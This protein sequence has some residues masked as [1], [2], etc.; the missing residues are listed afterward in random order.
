MTE[1]TTYS[2]LT[3]LRMMHLTGNTAIAVLLLGF[4]VVFPTMKLAAM[5]WGAAALAVGRRPAAAVRL[6]HHLGKFSMLDVLVIALFILA[7]KGLPGGTTIKLEW[8]V[9]AFAVSVAGSLVVSVIL[10]RTKPARGQPLTQIPQMTQ[11][12]DAD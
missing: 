2:I 7:A 12:R 8:G 5:G 10:G 4:S 3:G 6:T 11:N 9:W 1:A